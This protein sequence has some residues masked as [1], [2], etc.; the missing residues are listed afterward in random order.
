MR[1]FFPSKL[2]T[3]FVM[4]SIEPLGQANSHIPQP[5][6][7]CSLVPSLC[8]ITTSPRKRSNILS[9]SRFSG[10]CWVTFFQGVKKYLPVTFIPIKSVHIPL[11]IETI[12]SIN[13][14]IL[15]KIQLK[16]E[17]CQYNQCH[18]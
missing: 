3:D 17:F 8:H 18:Q 16:V 11:K 1:F 12:Y 9:V 7:L 13:C 14:F 10:Y 6:H 4:I 2:M 5:V 15:V